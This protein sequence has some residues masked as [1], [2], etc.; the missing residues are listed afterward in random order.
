MTMRVVLPA[1]FQEKIQLFSS[2]GGGEVDFQKADGSAFPVDGI[3]TGAGTDAKVRLI[4][5]S[6]S[7]YLNDV[8]VKSRVGQDRLAHED[9]TVI[10]CDYVQ[11]KG[12]DHD[13]EWDSERLVRLGV[14]T[15]N[16]WSQFSKAEAY[17]VMETTFKV[18]PRQ[19]IPVFYWDIKREARSRQW[20]KLKGLPPSDISK[21]DSDDDPNQAHEDLEQRKD[22]ELRVKDT[23]GWAKFGG[24]ALL[25]KEGTYTQK[26]TAKE[27]LEVSINERWYICSPYRRWYSKIQVKNTM[28]DGRSYWR[29][30]FITI[31]K[32]TLKVGEQKAILVN[33]KGG[34]NEI[35]EG[36]IP[37]KAATWVE[38][39]YSNNVKGIRVSL[40]DATSHVS[41]RVMGDGK[42]NANGN[43]TVQL[44]GLKK[45]A[46]S[47]A[48]K[49]PISDE[50]WALETVTVTEE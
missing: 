26:I 22:L 4:G 14:N 19:A 44:K 24:N 50:H 13:G 20:V 18:R 2:S 12:S 47:I 40:R 27:W 10:W 33:V 41:V 8:D 30:Y 38:G 37:G 29:R 5:T 49:I 43:V 7:S 28:P 35:L 39:S 32:V 3:L 36:E 34:E 11:F 15:N 17:N 46:G 48:F 9:L 31:P 45:G 25:S 23:P 21:E 1:G 6:T 16:L 42:T